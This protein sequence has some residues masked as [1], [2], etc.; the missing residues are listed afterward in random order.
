MGYG[1]VSSYDPES[2]RVST[3][4]IDRLGRRRGA[5]RPW[6]G[7]AHLPTVINERWWLTCRFD[8]TGVLLHDLGAEDPFSANVARDHPDVVR[9]LFEMA[10]GDAEGGFPECLQKVCERSGNAP[11]SID[12]SSLS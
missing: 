1:D 10:K 7:C 2:I 5:T 6:V 3:P 8:G 4:N 12:M 11:G 9:Q